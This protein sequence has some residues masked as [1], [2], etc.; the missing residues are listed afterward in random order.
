[1]NE[2]LLTSLRGGGYILYTKHGEANVGEDQTVPDFQN[3]STQRNLSDMGRRQ[4]IYYGQILNYYQIPISYPIQTSPFCRAIETAQLAFGSTNI[5]VDPYWYDIYR[6]SN[7]L[8]S[9]EQ[10]SI[11]SNLPSRLEITP[12]SGMNRVIIAHSF[13]DNIGLGQLSDLETVIIKPLGQGNGYEII[14]KLSLT[15]FSNLINN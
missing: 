8:S 1:M 5:Q 13:P 15:D 12:P 6:L 9:E 2:S 7:N 3:C 11:L 4:A 14:Q 10:N